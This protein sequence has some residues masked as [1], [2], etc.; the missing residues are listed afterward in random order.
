YAVL[1][2][3]DYGA[4]M[5]TILSGADA[6]GRRLRDHARHAMGPVWEANHVW[7]IFVLVICWTAYPRAFGSITSTLAIPLFL[8]AVG[9]ILRGT[10]YAVRGSV[11]PERAVAL[12]RLFGL[13]S[14]LTP[15]ALGAVAGGI[16]SGRVPVGNA[17]G[18]RWSSWLNP[19][20]VVLGLLFVATS[21]YLAAVYLAADAHRLREPDLEQAF[22]MR[23]I[24]GGVV[25]GGLAFAG[26]VVVH[27]DAERIWDGLTSG[28]GVAALVV[29]AV[30]G[31]ATMALVLRSRFEWA[32][33]A[34]TV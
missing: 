2:G 33:V 1:G 3:A 26:L 8:I 15:F 5:W 22:R 27:S 13:S 9:I 4:G 34:A 28:G 20:S 7:L 24:G 29:S 10:A 17:A 23:A 16:A 12:E 31:V 25:A 30:A 19:T 32:R 18:D 6:Y 11:D 21:A 14:V